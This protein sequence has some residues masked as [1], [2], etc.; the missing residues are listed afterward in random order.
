[1]KKLKFIDANGDAAVNFGP[2]IETS[3]E[4]SSSNS[5]ST[6]TI[7]YRPRE[8]KKFVHLVKSVVNDRICMRE[9]DGVV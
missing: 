1:M 4:W 6:P 9:G 5:S 8:I 2:E 7:P 3:A